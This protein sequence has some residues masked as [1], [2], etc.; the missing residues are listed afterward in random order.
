MI[1]ISLRRWPVLTWDHAKLSGSVLGWVALVACV[2][3]SGTYNAFAKLLS[4]GLSPL[5]LFFLSE[6]LTGFFVMFSFGV[7]PVFRGLARLKGKDLRSMILVGLLSGTTAPLLLFSGLRLSTAVNASLFG[8]LEP[9]F[10]VMLAVLVLG[11]RFTQRHIVAGIAVLI[12]MVTISLRGFTDG[13][14]WNA[15]DVLLVLASLAFA[16]GSIVFRKKLR[17]AQPHL[18]L[19]MRAVVAVS[20]FFLASPFISHPLIE[21]IRALPLSLVPVLIGFGFISRFLNVFTFY[22][23]L[24]RL[25]VTTVSLVVNLTVI[26]SIAFAWLLLG[27]PISWYHILGGGLIVLGTLI[28][29]S[30]CIHRKQEDHKHWETHLRQKN[31]R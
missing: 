26:V 25:P 9:V 8:N 20:C 23:A 29:E 2:F 22:E 18:V 12:G 21:E 14:Q 1:H 30:G 11:E 4:G 6:L 10:L 19:F 16:V 5:S 3:S 13:L 28:L 7:M 27:E 17:H 15:G 24:D 31:H